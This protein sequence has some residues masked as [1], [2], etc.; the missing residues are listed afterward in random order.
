MRYFWTAPRIYSDRLFLPSVGFYLIHVHISRLVAPA[1][2]WPTFPRKDTGRNCPTL[3]S[4]QDVGVRRLSKNMFIRFM[5]R[6]LK[7]FALPLEIGT[8]Q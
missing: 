1:C 8:H 7:F 5:S 3:S 4:K 2:L 6:K